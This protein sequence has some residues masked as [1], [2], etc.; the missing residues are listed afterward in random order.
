MSVDKST[1]E[2]RRKSIA[3]LTRL[4]LALPA[5]SRLGSFSALPYTGLPLGSNMPFRKESTEEAVESDLDNDDERHRFLEQVSRHVPDINSEGADITRDLAKLSKRPNVKR[6]HSFSLFALHTLNERRGST[7]SLLNVPGGF[8]REFMV[9]RKRKPNFLTANFVEFLSIYGHF[10]GELLEDDDDVACHYLAIAPHYEEQLFFVGD[11]SSH[12]YI[13]RDGTATDKKAYFLLLKA[14]V[15]TGVLFLPRAFASGGLMFSIVTLLGF[16][17][18]SYWCYLVLVFTKMATKVLS[19]ADIGYRLYG[20][21]LQQLIL[22]SIVVSQI[23]FVAAYMV[24]TSENLRA[25]V[26]N[27]G[28]GT[29]SADWYIAAQIVILAPLSLVRDITRLS[30]LAVLANL[31]IMVGLVTIL[32]YLCYEWLITNGGAFGPDIKYWFNQSEFSVFI[33]VAIFAFEGIGLII[34]IQE[35]MVY[36][37]HFPWVLGKVLLTIS[38]VFIG[39]GTLG[40]V[41]FGLNIQTVILLNLPQ[42]SPFVI[43][44]QLLYSLAILLSTPLQLFPAIRLIESKMFMATGKHSPGIKWA[45]NTFRFMFVI[46]TALIAL[47]G[48]K[49]LDRFVSFIGCFACIPLV[50]MYPPVLHLKSCCQTDPSLLPRENQKRRWLG[51]LD[52]FLLVIGACTLVYT[53]ADLLGWFN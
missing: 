16:G 38:A 51:Y 47:V 14:F 5:G 22:M 53:T 26:N 4:P 21:W 17:L 1:T 7:A 23:G 10:A 32:Y 28:G 36:P 27:I 31:F 50:Y 49:S 9:S 52:C 41:T 30:L 13:N 24:F 15:G 46:I 12:N 39:M 34:P 48:G 11:S 37:N 19:F 25:F 44:I 6:L 20:Q 29:H 45:K 35:S 18:L 40:Y 8:R 2:S 33:G 3:M 42:D 43:M